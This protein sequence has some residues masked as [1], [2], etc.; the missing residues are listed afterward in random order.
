MLPLSLL[1]LALLQGSSA[2]GAA[3]T[4]AAATAAAEVTVFQAGEGGYYMHVNP[5]M[6]RL[7]SS[8]TLLVFSEA[9]QA[10]GRIHCH[11][12]GGSRWT[13]WVGRV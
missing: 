8:N 6:V 7:P 2:R 9:R 11:A 1:A 12:A 10:V 5:A 13:G 3:A 4:T